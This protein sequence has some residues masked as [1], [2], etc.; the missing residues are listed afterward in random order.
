M[1]NR[2]FTIS[3]IENLQVAYEAFFDEAIA[4]TKMFKSIQSSAATLQAQ[5]PSNVISGALS[6]ATATQYSTSE[7]EQ[8]K[9]EMNKTLD[10]IKKQI[11]DID[12]QM[13]GQLT[14]LSNI[15]GTLKGISG[16]YLSLLQ[17]GVVELPASDFLNMIQTVRVSMQDQLAKVEE[18]YQSLIAVS[19]GLNVSHA[20]YAG[21]PINVCTGNF[22]IEKQ[23]LVVESAFPLVFKRTFNSFGHYHGVLGNKWQHN[24]EEQLTILDNGQ[25]IKLLLDDSR[26]F[27]FERQ[28]TGYS[29]TKTPFYRLEQVSDGYIVMDVYGVTY[30][31]SSLGNLMTKATAKGQTLYYHYDKMQRLIKV[32]NQDQFL[33]LRYNLSGHLESV[34]DP[35]FN[36]V[37]FEYEENSLIAVVRPN[38][39]KESYKNDWR[40]NI[41]S[42]TNA[43]GITVLKNKYDFLGR[44]VSQEFPDG[45][46]M[47]FSYD[48]KKL[49]TTVVERNGGVTYYHRDDQY[50]HV[51]TEDDLGQITIRYNDQNRMTQTID[52]N[53]YV[54]R[55]EYNES[56]K[57]SKVTN[58]LN[59]VTTLDYNEDGFVQS[60][61]QANGAKVI[62]QYQD[63]LLVAATDALG[64]K[65]RYHYNDKK[66][67][68]EVSYPDGSQEVF[69]YNDKGQL[70]S[71]QDAVGGI[72]SLQYDGCGRV[73]DV[74]NPLGGHRTYE[75]DS[76]GNLVRFTNELGL[77]QIF[78]YTPLNKVETVTD[79]DGKSVYYEYNELG[80]VSKFRNKDEQ[81]TIYQYDDMW[82][83]SSITMPNQAIVKYKYDLHNR[84]SMVVNPLGDKV[85]FEYDANGNR[86]VVNHPDGTSS[87]FEYDAL[88]RCTSVQKPDG[89]VAQYTYNSMNKVEKVLLPNGRFVK[90][91]YDL[92]GQL[93]MR[94]DSH[95]RTEHFEYTSMGQLS[96]YIDSNDHIT[97]YRYNPGGQ[98]CSVRDPLGNVYRYEYD[99]CQRRVASYR[100]NDLMEN[101]QYDAL[102][103]LSGA[104]S[105]A[106]GQSYYKHDVN[107]NITQVQD[108]LGHITNYEY[109]ALGHL[110]RVVDALGHVTEYC[111]DEVGNRTQTI[112]YANNEGDNPSEHTQKQFYG[113][114]LMG[115][116]TS[117][118]NALGLVESYQ[119]DEMGRLVIKQAT[120]GIS[121]HYAYLPGTNLLS[122][123]QNEEDVVNY[124]YDN[125][126][127]LS[128][129]EDWLGTTD[130]K[131]NEEGQLIQVDDVHNQK[132]QYQWDNRGRCASLLYPSGQEVHYQYD[133][134]NRLVELA[135]G[136]N[137]Y[138]YA[139]DS[140]GRLSSK[141]FAD[142]NQ[143][144]YNYSP[145]G[146][147]AS[148][149]LVNQDSLLMRREYEYNEVGNL[150][151]L[152]IRTPDA[153]QSRRYE[154]DGL[155]QLVASYDQ[156]S[157]IEQFEYDAFGNRIR[158]RNESGEQHFL[159]NQANQLVSEWGHNDKAHYGY[160]MRGN[161][162][163]RQDGSGQ[164]LYSYNWFNQ[165]T[166]VQLPS[167]QIH[168][169]DYNALGHRI[170]EH[171][172]SPDGR[173]QSFRNVIDPLR[174][175][176]R[177]IERQSEQ[178][179]SETYLWDYSLLSDGAGRQFM[180]GE[181]G[182][183]V[184]HWDERGHLEALRYASFG[185]TASSL[186]FGYT[187]HGYSPD[188]EL[189]Y[190]ENRYY[191]PRTA[192]FLSVDRVKDVASLPQ[193]L[194]SYTYVWNNPMNLV[195][196]DGNFPNPFEAVGNA[197][198][199]FSVGVTNGM[200]EIGKATVEFGK[201]AVKAVED[202]AVNVTRFGREVVG[203]AGDMFEGA[204][205][206]T[207]GYI[208]ENIVG[209]DYEL[210]GTAD[211]RNPNGG[212]Y[213][214]ASASLTRHVGGKWIVF[215]VKNNNP[216]GVDLNLP[217]YHQDEQTGAK[218]G[219]DLKTGARWDDGFTVLAESK[220]E[221]NSEGSNAKFAIGF[222]GKSLLKLRATAGTHDKSLEV[223]GGF[224]A[225]LAGTS[226]IIATAKLQASDSISKLDIELKGEWGVGVN[227][228][229]LLLLGGSLAGSIALSTAA[230]EL[231]SAISMSL[232]SLGGGPVFAGVAALF[233][234]FVHSPA[235]DA[236]KMNCGE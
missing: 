21:D 58:A 24:Y 104:W 131:W 100:N 42:I 96:R 154:Y 39:A 14:S 40:G 128:S 174:R 16:N 216:T 220:T 163:S 205:N 106:D 31:F 11:P 50:R 222:G 228:L 7:F 48:D 38:G 155:S 208:G 175:R 183:I 46:I 172:I 191:D 223:E 89:R 81:T 76:V 15:V 49:V 80:K 65:T 110:I 10:R 142:G 22:T 224:E 52:R 206:A 187:G 51:K 184:A 180:E 41:E 95:G 227:T 73:S 67:L 47:T 219:V 4:L 201:G 176:E 209:F 102:G 43:R 101:Y 148:L 9:D 25:K 107:N 69:T 113:Y 170:S 207:T 19:K 82:N 194:N 229:K 158:A 79:F 103:R 182:N 60:I 159:Y 168:R 166:E 192:Q 195:D 26:E 123:V 6:D 213:L 33:R 234:L 120:D 171:K 157:L 189:V 85:T 91:T 140:Y 117:H 161:R 112:Q 53:G 66:E 62:M 126:G 144:T 124:H 151:N 135:Q 149:S 230:P 153:Q 115:R 114:D 56:G 74:E 36:V 59:E 198:G 236:K 160:D 162:I 121:T 127:R 78:T 129:I 75:Y 55:Y 143:L 45:N 8:M 185:Q 116:I 218:F 202:T 29:C 133:Q 190:A 86:T 44:V 68:V 23:D 232:P 64:H 167:Q 105:I 93:I 150:V 204:W 203:R 164:T 28:A 17:S 72:T 63:N 3:E 97:E 214:G 35:Q 125:E 134:F 92:Q 200:A 145:A 141:Q 196:P 186:T 173:A 130:Y 118:T 87:R 90:M 147:L 2:V 13:A 1:T 169:Y 138:R 211:N 98:L 83:I 235:I 34:M 99:A 111:Y 119:Y 137:R 226:D 139:Y 108:A 18:I 132:V 217:L 12:T 165:L 210:E 30:K 225:Q 177:P 212:A 221:E 181:L 109:D 215:K 20:T 156:N 188:T 233:S 61:V 197:I 231:M 71:V 88:N 70:V 57:L 37:T 193:S 27:V 146:R 77:T 179:E 122:T 84:I 152:D 54:T 32:S 199:D 94:Q 136:E 178:T 5:V